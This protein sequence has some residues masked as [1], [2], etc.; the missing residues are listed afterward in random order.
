MK[1]S[2]VPIRKGW[3]ELVHLGT[4]K[5]SLL[6]VD[7][8]DNLTMWPMAAKEMHLGDEAIEQQQSHNDQ[9]SAQGDERELHAAAHGHR[10]GLLRI[11]LLFGIIIKRMN[12]IVDIIIVYQFR[13]GHFETS[14]AV[15]SFRTT[16][17]TGWARSLELRG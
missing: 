6:L 11:A 5:T 17:G 9:V 2:R 16:Q 13:H 7:R 3:R 4:N 15:I 14:F 1:A 12:H 10:P 8:D